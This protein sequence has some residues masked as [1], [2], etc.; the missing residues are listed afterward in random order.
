METPIDSTEVI[1]I[2]PKATKTQEEKNREFEA[3]LQKALAVF[4]ASGESKLITSQEEMDNA[5]TGIYDVQFPSEDGC[6]DLG[7]SNFSI[8][9]FIPKGASR[10]LSQIAINALDIDINTVFELNQ[11]DDFALIY[12]RR[13]IATVTDGVESRVWSKFVR[14]DTITTPLDLVAEFELTLGNIGL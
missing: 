2:T 8:I 1:D 9:S 7:I 3:L 10:C 4:I 13:G 5:S 11:E 6:V 14:T 12:M